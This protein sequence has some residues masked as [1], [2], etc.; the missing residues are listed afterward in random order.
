MSPQHYKP[1]LQISPMLYSSLRHGGFLSFYHREV[2]HSGCSVQRHCGNDYD[3][4]VVAGVRKYYLREIITRNACHSPC[5][6]RESV[7]LGD[8]LHS[9]A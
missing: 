2:D 7:Y 1:G 3:R 5:R 8:V 6:E 9:E 4:I